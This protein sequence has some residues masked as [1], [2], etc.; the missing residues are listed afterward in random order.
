[1]AYVTY[2]EGF[3]SGGFN[4][5]AIRAKITPALMTPSQLR[6]G[7]QGPS[8]PLFDNRFQL[9]LAAFTVKYDDKQ[10]D[11]VKPGDRWAGHI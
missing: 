2:S 11:I 4:G 10:E 5:R 1:M 3:R 6:A 7:R 9:N 8:S